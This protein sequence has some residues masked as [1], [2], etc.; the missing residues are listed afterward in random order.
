MTRR[1]GKSKRTRTDA[2][3]ATRVRAA[4]LRDPAG[5]TA[6]SGFA[7]RA[8]RA[9]EAPLLIPAW[10]AW[11][12]ER[13][14]HTAAFCYQLHYPPLRDGRPHWPDGEFWTYERIMRAEKSAR[15][16]ERARRYHADRPG[17]ISAYSPPLPDDAEFEAALDAGR[18]WTGHFYYLDPAPDV[19]ADR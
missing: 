9:V 8:A 14:K 6:V 3:A 16:T 1:G 7:E 12:A 15:A 2:S 19:G 18:E 13:N 4:A 11:I 5:A 17:L 10:I